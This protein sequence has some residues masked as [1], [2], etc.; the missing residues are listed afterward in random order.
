ML[1][2]VVNDMVSITKKEKGE[3][4]L[5]YLQQTVRLGDEIRTLSRAIGHD[6]SSEEV[7]HL[8]LEY[9]DELIFEAARLKGEFEGKKWKS[10]LLSSDDIAFLESVKY[11]FKKRLRGLGKGD[12][13]I[14]GEADEITYIQGTLFIEGI[15]LTKEETYL[16]TY[17]SAVPKEKSLRDV[18]GAVNMKKAVD[19]RESH[20][21]DITQNFIKNLHGII[22]QG[23]DDTTGEYR[24]L[25]VALRYTDF[26]P[27][28]PIL[29]SEE[30]AK[31]LDWYEANKKKIHPL[32]LATIFHGM[33]ESIHPFL[34]GNGRV[35]R[36][37]FNFTL[38]KHGSPPILFYAEDRLDY[39]D[40]MKDANYERYEKLKEFILNQYKKSLQ[41]AREKGLLK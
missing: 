9:K 6:L 37:L 14:V 36:E 29:V 4:A 41:Q 10:E 31:L 38:D 2:N 20:S 25:A 12:I 16:I 1:I 32:E 22:M 11:I 5:Y 18:Y 34:D 30:I 13:K 39:L 15:E 17:E 23:I 19:F 24:N 26:V 35:G 8:Y 7:K 28:P 33:F 27:P 3:K 40:A 21:G